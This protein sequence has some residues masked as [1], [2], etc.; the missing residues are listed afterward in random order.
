MSEQNPQQPFFQEARSL[1][2][3]PDS[4]E[5]VRS[6]Q[7]VDLRKV[8]EPMKGSRWLMVD[9]QNSRSQIVLVSPDTDTV[10]IFKYAPASGTDHIRARC[11]AI[12]WAQSNDIEKPASAQGEAQPELVH[13]P[14]RMRG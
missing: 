12:V 13:Q 1:P 3:A 10:A 11:R 4:V 2:D 7:A 14:L 6:W 8:A 5:P 9:V